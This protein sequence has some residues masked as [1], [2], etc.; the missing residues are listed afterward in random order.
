MGK[1]KL[2]WIL[3]LGGWLA[4]FAFNTIINNLNTTTYDRLQWLLYCLTYVIGLLITIA[5]RH[6][7]R[8]IYSKFQKL[9]WLPITMIV[10]SIT[11]TIIW[12]FLDIYISQL[13]WVNGALEIKNY[14]QPFY[15]IRHNYIF[16]IVLMAWSGFYFG[17]KYSLDWQKEKE[18][19]LRAQTLAQKAQMQMLRYQLNPHFLFNS[20]NSIQ[21]L[22]DENKDHAKEMVGELSEFLRYSLLHKEATFVNLSN[23]IEAIKHYF[24]IEKKRF[25]EKLQIEYNIDDNAR[26]IQVLTFLLHPLIENAVKHGMRTSPMPL[27]IKL[28]AARTDYGVLIEVSNTG[29]WVDKNDQSKSKG[30]GTG[31]TN[32]KER[33]ENAYQKNHRFNIV[34]HEENTCIQI[35]IKEKYLSL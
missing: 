19:T 18:N 21:V 8:L 3:Q 28:T 35:E 22:I 30:T 5:M 15:M 14:L 24:A 9:I 20:L 26:N 16:L 23:E 32:V 4:Y 17:I 33:L 34:K 6:L 12:Y 11:F 27:C 29:R 7:Y 13:F 25:E 1:N 2:F 31:L 10:A